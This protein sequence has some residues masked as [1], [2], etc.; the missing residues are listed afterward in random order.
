MATTKH[1]TY[2]Q[3]ATNILTT[4]LNTLANATNSAASAAI[5]NTT[6]LDLFMDLEL[7][8]AAATAARSAGAAI[9]V[10]IVPTIDGGTNYVD[11]EQTTAELIAGFTLDAST[12][13]RRAMIRDLPIPPSLFK[14]FVRNVTGQPLNASGNVLRYRTHNVQVV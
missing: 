12:T 9:Y 3:S 2:T 5:D 14:L 10:Y 4:E 1:A 13:A 8:V 6:N 11:V 7:Y